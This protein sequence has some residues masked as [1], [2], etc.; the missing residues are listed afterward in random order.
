MPTLNQFEI[1]KALRSEMVGRI[2]DY[3]GQ[4]CSTAV[5]QSFMDLRSKRVAPREIHSDKETDTDMITRAFFDVRDD[6]R[7]PDVYV[8][9][10]VRNGRFL[11]RCR[12]L[13]ACSSEY[14]LNKA[15]LN[16]RK[17]N[18]LKNLQSRPLRLNHER[19]VFASEFAATELRYRTGATVDDIICD[20]SLAKEFDDIAAKIAPGFTSLEYR[21]AMLNVRKSGRDKTPFVMPQFKEPIQLLSDT[22]S[23]PASRGVYVLSDQSRT[24]YVHGTANLNGGIALHRQL[25]FGSA[26]A[27]RLWNPNP[28]DLL[29][30]YAMIPEAKFLRPIELRLISERKPLFNI[31][32]AA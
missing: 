9:D 25:D 31:I 14:A 17:A 30:S 24:L 16:A 8:A 27:N 12:Q 13:G 3:T 20:P 29:V 5:A 4:I 18:R 22:L 26:F 23:L 2:S 7:S 6:Q 15:L 21:W 28:N 11:E 1:A 19:Y 10:P 32:S